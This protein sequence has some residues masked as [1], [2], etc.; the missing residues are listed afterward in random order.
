MHIIL[1]MIEFEVYIFVP[2]HL[3]PFRTSF[4]CYRYNRTNIIDPNSYLIF[5]IE[6]S[7]LGKEIDMAERDRQER[8]I[9]NRH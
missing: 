6:Q 3:E 4:E 1:L 7:Y 9:M 8:E 5:H 2:L